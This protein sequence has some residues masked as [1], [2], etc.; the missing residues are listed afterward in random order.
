MTAWPRVT[1]YFFST[2]TIWL[3]PILTV[4]FGIFP[5]NRNGTL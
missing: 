1:N 2:G 4:S 3:G 5:V